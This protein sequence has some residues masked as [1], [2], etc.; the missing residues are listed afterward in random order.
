MTTGAL[1]SAAASR[2]LA[3][4]SQQ[5]PP[6]T[7]SDEPLIQFHADTKQE[8]MSAHSVQTSD[9]AVHLA[10]RTLAQCTQQKPTITRPITLTS[11]PYLTLPAGVV[12]LF[13]FE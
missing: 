4:C 11:D 5:H 2:M 10:T 12:R 13:V 6:N 1:S 9:A 3:S 8:K 7:V